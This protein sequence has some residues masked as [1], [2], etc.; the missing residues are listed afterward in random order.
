VELGFKPMP[1]LTA[2]NTI[3][4]NTILFLKVWGSKAGGLL[5]L[6]HHLANENTCKMLTT[7]PNLKC[8]ERGRRRWRLSKIV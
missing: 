2:T 3:N 6:M 4:H 8:F 7:P 5:L 1:G